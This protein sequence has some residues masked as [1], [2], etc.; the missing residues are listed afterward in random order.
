MRS[1]LLPVCFHCIILSFLLTSTIKN[2]QQIQQK[3][4]PGLL[5]NWHM[6]LTF[7]L[8]I[9]YTTQTNIINI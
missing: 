1:S 6:D 7:L 5:C 9:E 3:Q 4:L 2:E 8:G